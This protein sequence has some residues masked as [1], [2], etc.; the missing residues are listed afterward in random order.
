[1]KSMSIRRSS[2]TVI[3]LTIGLIITLIGCSSSGS[4]G[5]SA[6]PATDLNKEAQ[7][8]A[9]HIFELIYAKCGDAY[10]RSGDPRPITNLTVLA[11]AW[12]IAPN[13]VRPEKIFFGYQWQGMAN[14]TTPNGIG[15]AF[16]IYRR[17]GHW[18]LRP[19]HGSDAQDVA[20]DVLQ[21]VRPECPQR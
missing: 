1:M 9:Q 18:F 16:E 2:A 14:I 12:P 6:V 4:K 15:E 19:E 11:E 21:P 7:Q 17:G 10:Y 8:Q 3:F 13:G 20:I 5:F